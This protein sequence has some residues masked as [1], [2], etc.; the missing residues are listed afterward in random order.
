MR[1]WAAI[2]LVLFGCSGGSDDGDD[3]TVSRDGGTAI[4][5]AYATCA[6]D[7]RVGQL[8]LELRASFTSVQ[9]AVTDGVRPI[10]VPVVDREAGD[11]RLVSPPTLFC[12]PA[13]GAGTT[14]SA[15]GQCVALPSNQD[16]G[17]VTITGLTAPVTMTA[18]APVYFYNFLGD[19]PHPAFAHGDAIGMSATMGPSIATVGVAALEVTTSSLAVARDVPST[20]EWTPAAADDGVRMEVELSIANHGGT[21]G[22]ILCTTDD[23]GAFT[24]PVELTN[25][26][27]DRGFSGFPSVTLTRQGAGTGDTANGCVELIARSEVVVPIEIPGLTSC[28]T[29]DD[30][31]GAETCQPD[32]TCG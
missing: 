5:G 10:D 31:R 20:L 29:D 3:T 19:L 4:A 26:L 14:C 6:D 2:A 15:S 7:A 18:R 24:I 12:D 11:C 27:L 32:L 16:V 9:G 21:P 30:C 8:V 1:R 17:E 25:A 22:R 23:S 28:S 13:C